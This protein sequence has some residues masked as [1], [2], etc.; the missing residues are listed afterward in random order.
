MKQVAMVTVTC[1]LL[2]R[3]MWSCDD[4]VT[5]TYHGGSRSLSSGQL[6][7]WTKSCESL[8][9]SIMSCSYT[10]FATIVALCNQFPLISKQKYLVVNSFIHQK[11]GDLSCMCLTLFSWDYIVVLIRCFFPF[12]NC[13]TLQNLI[14]EPPQQ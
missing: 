13:L 6:S 10:I 1:L 4:H 2:T 9:Q 3:V 5:I 8:P 11:Q 14:L 12:Y 7:K